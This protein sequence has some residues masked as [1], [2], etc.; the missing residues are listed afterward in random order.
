MTLQLARA[1]HVIVSSLA[2]AVI[3]I[4]D[5]TQKTLKES[6]CVCA[7][8]GFSTKH[9]WTNPEDPE[10]SGRCQKVYLPELRIIS[11]A[12]LVG[13]IRDLGWDEGFSP[14]LTAPKLPRAIP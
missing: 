9:L 14:E 12:R 2:D 4:E 3:V 10:G 6:R 1:Y 11:V 5:L 8:D 13:R 7:T